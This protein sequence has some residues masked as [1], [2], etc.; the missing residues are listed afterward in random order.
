MV[1]LAACVNVSIA[2]VNLVIRRRSSFQKFLSTSLPVLRSKFCCVLMM[3]VRN[4]LAM[5]RCRNSGSYLGPGPDPFFDLLT[6]RAASSDLIRG[7][8]ALSNA[9][10]RY[11]EHTFSKSYTIIALTWSFLGSGGS[12]WLNVC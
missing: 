10:I 7:E 9:E 8:E 4:S 5:I 2:E 11:L 6:K 1:V 12:C 3:V